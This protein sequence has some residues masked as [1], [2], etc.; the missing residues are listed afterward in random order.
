MG[1]L[2][3]S[4]SIW[5]WLILLIIF[6]PIILGGLILGFQKKV[7]IKHAPS[8]LIKN[9][10][11]GWS[12]TYFFFGWLVPIFRGEIGVGVLHLVLTFFTCGIFQIVMSFLYNKQFMTRMLTNGWVLADTE[13]KNN[14][15]K[16]KLR[17]VSV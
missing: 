13:E 8:G 11:V 4:F 16:L 14:F 17:M 15:A 10:Y 12:W 6:S 9:G 1:I 5:H 2:M 3:G 7:L